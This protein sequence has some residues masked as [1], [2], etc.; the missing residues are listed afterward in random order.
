MFDEKCHVSPLFVFS[1]YPSNK[2]FQKQK[3]YSYLLLGKQVLDFGVWDFVT[4]YQC[5]RHVM[6]FQFGTYTHLKSTNVK[7]VTARALTLV[8]HT[9]SPGPVQERRQ[10]HPHI[11]VWVSNQTSFMSGGPSPE[12]GLQLLG[13]KFVIWSLLSGCIFGN[14]IHFQYEIPVKIVLL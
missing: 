11:S 2:T 10:Q 13:W 6:R 14:P 1:K 9:A 5:L 8:S 4:C 12:G 7:N 3:G